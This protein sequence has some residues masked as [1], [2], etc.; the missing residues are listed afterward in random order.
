[1][2]DAD[3]DQK[4]TH[5]PLTTLAFYAAVPTRVDTAITVHAAEQAGSSVSSPVARPE[6]G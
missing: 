2:I 3:V 6:P 5:G 1:M 4:W